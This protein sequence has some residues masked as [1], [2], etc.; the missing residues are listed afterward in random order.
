M[1]KLNHAKIS[2]TEATD[3]I[4]T[5]RVPY[6]SALQ[7]LDQ[8][9]R[10]QDFTPEG[11]WVVSCMEPYKSMKSNNKL[12]MK[13]TEMLV[14]RLPSR[15]G[16]KIIG[17]SFCH[18]VPCKAGLRHRLDFYPHVDYCH[19]TGLLVKHVWKRLQYLQDKYGHHKVFTFS[20]I[21]PEAYSNNVL[22]E[23]FR[24][25][26]LGELRQ[27]PSLCIAGKGLPFNLKSAL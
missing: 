8:E 13:D 15:D 6:E 5:T 9:I 11:F 18:V 23:C 1:E 17:L 10:F 2:E 25:L 14:S 16:D 4:V 7:I 20:I 19:N 22:S 26:G 27:E 21:L 12:I 24:Q 3:Q